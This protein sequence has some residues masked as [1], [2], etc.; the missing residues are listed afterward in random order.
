MWNGNGVL[1]QTGPPCVAAV[2]GYM[3]IAMTSAAQGVSVADASSR[4]G[5]VQQ[6]ST[7]S[8]RHW[9]V[10]GHVNHLKEINGIL[11]GDLGVA[12][13][14]QAT[15][16]ERSTAYSTNGITTRMNVFG[17]STV[18]SVHTNDTRASA[19][20]ANLASVDKRA[21]LPTTTTTSL[22]VGW[23]ASR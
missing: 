20:F 18:L 6:T 9:S 7:P 11:G 3:L 17:D 8:V 2:I 21:S 13:A 1:L 12:N 15:T 5:D 23:M 16:I 10:S 22:L 14:L 19:S 4:V